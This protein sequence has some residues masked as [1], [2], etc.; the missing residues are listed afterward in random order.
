M[1]PS[2]EEGKIETF[3]SS[4]DLAFQRGFVDVLRKC[5]SGLSW[6]AACY[7]FNEL[8]GMPSTLG[9]A[10]MLRRLRN[11]AAPYSIIIPPETVARA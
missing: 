10:D 4:G 6:K 8:S 5:T 2:C 1:S 9:T 11:L 7:A 3:L